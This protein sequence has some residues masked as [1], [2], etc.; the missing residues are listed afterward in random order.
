[1]AA[2]CL[3]R[4]FEL[5]PRW[6][7]WRQSG[8]PYLQCKSCA[9]KQTV[10]NNLTAIHCDIVRD[11]L[12][13]RARCSPSMQHANRMS[14]YLLYLPYHRYSA[15]PRRSGTG[16]EL[17]APLQII[18]GDDRK[19]T[20]ANNPTSTSAT[21]AA[22]PANLSPAYFQHSHSF[23]HTRYRPAPLHAVQ[24]DLAPHHV[25]R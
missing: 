10:Y 22:S 14:M 7:C 16:S 4:W 6:C 21:T 3:W 15:R 9:N 18:A 5:P 11:L 13:S 19:A 23:P 24:P 12:C 8:A 1:M 20:P 25:G 17:A 2:S